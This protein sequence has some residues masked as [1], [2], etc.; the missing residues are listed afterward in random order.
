VSACKGCDWA[1]TNSPC[2]TCPDPGHW[3]RLK[4]GNAEP[5]VK[6]GKPMEPRAQGGELCC[7]EATPVE[8]AGGKPRYWICR[9]HPGVTWA[10]SELPAPRSTAPTPPAT[11]LQGLV[12]LAR[13]VG[14]TFDGPGIAGLCCMCGEEPVHEFHLGDSPECFGEQARRA[15]AA[16]ESRGAMALDPALDSLV[17]DE[18]TAEDG[19]TLGERIRRLLVSLDHALTG[20]RGPACEKCG[21]N[22]FIVGWVDTHPY[23][24]GCPDCFGEG[25]A[26]PPQTTKGDSHG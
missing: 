19:A 17:Y 9:V 26:R 18:M 4:E 10:L 22:G 11:A 8:N 7:K 16:W 25:F 6:E 2:A 12:G 3:Q 1:F 21:G 5:P 20:E 13:R 23:Q 14:K 15:L 24:E